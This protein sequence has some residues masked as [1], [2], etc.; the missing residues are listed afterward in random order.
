[1][2]SLSLGFT[3]IRG[4]FV[5]EWDFIHTFQSMDMVESTQGLETLLVTT[6]TAV[7][8]LSCWLSAV[9]DTGPGAVLC[10]NRCLRII[11]L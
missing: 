6:T 11:W 4:C 9:E 5:G 8:A 3:F 2:A 7:L 1:M 10:R